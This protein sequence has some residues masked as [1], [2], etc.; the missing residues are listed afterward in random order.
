MLQ[1]F[2]KIIFFDI[3]FNRVGSAVET[4]PLPLNL[5][6]GRSLLIY[7]Y[8]GFTKIL[9]FTNTVSKKRLEKGFELPLTSTIFQVKI[10][11]S[12]IG[13]IRRSGELA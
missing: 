1:S 6:S 5:S 11:V 9:N 13:F 2:A 12:A 3:L 7:Q 4:G 10:P 8:S